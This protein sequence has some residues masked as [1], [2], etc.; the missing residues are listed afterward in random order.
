MYCINEIAS[1]KHTTLL[2]LL[3][4]RPQIANVFSVMLSVWEQTAVT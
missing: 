1:F 2:F 4:I 3:L